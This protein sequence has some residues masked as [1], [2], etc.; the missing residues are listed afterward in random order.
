MAFWH[1]LGGAQNWQELP[2]TSATEADTKGLRSRTYPGK[3]LGSEGFVKQAMAA[4]AAKMEES[5]TGIVPARGS[6]L[7]EHEYAEVVASD[8]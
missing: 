3:S 6:R 8:G 5:I 7:S 4:L 1:Q 2:I